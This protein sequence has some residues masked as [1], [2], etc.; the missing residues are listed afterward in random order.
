VETE[1]AGEVERS[2]YHGTVIED[3]SDDEDAG[4]WPFWKPQAVQDCAGARA[5]EAEAEDVGS[6]ENKLLEAR[7]SNFDSSSD[8]KP[9]RCCRCHEDVLHSVDFGCGRAE[10]DAAAE[11]TILDFFESGEHGDDS[12]LALGGVPRRVHFSVQTVVGP[13]RWIF[14]TADNSIWFSLSKFRA[15]G[16]TDFFA[17]ASGAV[18]ADGSP[19]AA[20]GEGRVSFSLWGHLFRRMPVRIMATLPSRVL[21]GNRFIR[22]GLRMAMDLK[23]GRRQ[24]S[25]SV[26][27]SLVTDT[28]RVTANVP[29]ASL[30]EMAAVASED[31]DAKIAGLDL[32][33]LDAGHADAEKLLTLLTK[34]EQVFIARP[35]F[36]RQ[37]QKAQAFPSPPYLEERPGSFI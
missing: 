22:S 27:D 32:S 3:V 35:P 30:Q 33:Q 20:I 5:P 9:E 15:A 7:V 34:Y 29:P 18:S 17:T 14:D 26:G 21:L 25:L 2:G 11:A 37:N 4:Q 19:L 31:I 8:E 23:S 16:G 13:R 12:H 10:I 6:C 28:E 1:A 24:F 36:C